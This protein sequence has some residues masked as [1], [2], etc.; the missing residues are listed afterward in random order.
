MAYLKVL[1]GGKSGQ[2]WELK[3]P[4]T[5]LGRHPDCDIPIDVPDASRRHAQI[6]LDADAYYLED[7]RSR[8]GTSLND[9]VIQSRQKLNDG[10]RIRITTVVL[11][12]LAE[13]STDKPL[14]K[15][16]LS[17]FPPVL[18]CFPDSPPQQ[19]DA[20]EPRDVHVTEH[21]H[22][23]SSA[24]L[25]LRAKLRALTEISQSLRK[26]LVLDEV[27]PQILQSLLTIFPSAHRGLIALSDESGNVVPR[28][29][30]LRHGDIDENEVANGGAISISHTI[31]QEVM[32]SQKPLLSTD[33]ANDVRF[34]TSN[35]LL[36][37]PIRSMMCAP[38]IDAAGN[39][40]GVLQI[41]STQPA[42]RFREVDLDLFLSVA[43]Q[44][45][46]CIEYA[47]LHESLLRQQVAEHELEVAD[48]IQRSLLPHDPPDLPGYEFASYYQPAHRI[49]GDF[50]DYL[51][52][53]DGRLAVLVADVVGHG[54]EAALWTAKL[55]AE[56]R[57]RLLS[58]PRPADAVT[59]L[60]AALH[61]DIAMDRF[62]TLLLA[63]IDPNTHCVT[64]VNAGHMPPVR[65]TYDGRIANLIGDQCQLPLG[66]ADWTTYDQWSVRLEAGDVLFMHT[67][68]LNKAMNADEQMY[69]VDRIHKVM[70]SWGAPE[71]LSRRMQSDLRQFL[72]DA[73]QS[74]DMCWV[75]FG[76][77]ERSRL[78]VQAPGVPL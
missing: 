38:L 8:N 7:L 11:K 47:R 14:E 59:Q 53:P 28:W 46:I 35:S 21:S 6:V 54:L 41:D 49:G 71:D 33:A 43:A 61:R 52:L 69:G 63:V 2:V 5:V 70:Q 48:Q 40:F 37:A 78:T 20:E 13:S 30:R 64:L 73:P 29:I 58:V 39:S 3:N 75:C 67:D 31:V 57:V 19:A 45:S 34:I 51:P 66:V 16:G 10:D 72:G 44:A 9:E 76:R 60:G 42:S 62:V 77:H 56:I 4:V 12:F 15:S 27:F 50:Y 74:D 22:E 23:P 65:R 18:E 68:G 25:G 24:E 17:N 26:V 36:S 55:A 32:Q 1:R